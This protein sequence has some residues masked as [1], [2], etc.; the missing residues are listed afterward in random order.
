MLKQKRAKVKGVELSLETWDQDNN[1]KLI[2]PEKF[3]RTSWNSN[4]E[5]GTDAL[6][7]Q[8]RRKLGTLKFVSKTLLMDNT[9]RFVTG[10][11]RR[12]NTRTLM[13]AVD[14]LEIG[15]L[16]ALHSLVTMWK[17]IWMSSPLYMHKKI[18]YNDATGD[19]STSEPR[20]QNTTTSIRWRT[21]QLWNQ[22]PVDLKHCQSLPAFKRQARRWIL[23]RRDLEPD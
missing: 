6:L 22:L 4:L 15:E 18:D 11:G 2:Q 1:L 9:A 13:E 10:L 5:S 16:V 23:S 3:C 12:V 14:W 7:P 21:C 17:V 8:L 20:L 19:I